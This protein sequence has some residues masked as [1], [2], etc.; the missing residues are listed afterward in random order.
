MQVTVQPGSLQFVA[1]GGSSSRAHRGATCISLESGHRATKRP[2]RKQEMTSTTALKTTPS[3]AVRACVALA[4]IV[5]L[6]AA[7][8]QAERSSRQAVQESQAAFNRT[9]VKLPRVEVAGRR[10]AAS[11]PVAVRAAA[12]R[13]VG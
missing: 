4:V 7:W 11:A 13:P 2:A 8:V 5:V 9:Y 10:D 1:R 6:Y 3:L 12:K